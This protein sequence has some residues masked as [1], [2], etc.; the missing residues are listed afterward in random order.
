MTVVYGV[1]LQMP[2]KTYRSSF[3]R[4]VT[5]WLT[6]VLLTLIVLFFAFE[7]YPRFDA[8]GVIRLTCF[9]IMLAGILLP[10]TGLF[11]NHLSFVQ[12]TSLKFFDENLELSRN[13][14]KITIRLAEIYEVVEFSTN[15]KY[16]SGKLPWSQLV[17]WK[18]KTLEHEF[19]ISSLIISD[20]DLKKR[21]GIDLT[22]QLSY[23]PVIKKT[24]GFSENDEF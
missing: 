7:S 12:N 11:F 16:S 9:A 8:S 4:I 18:V 19:F 5:L 24:K 1:V 6:P 17:K 21:I 15:T 22:Y 23:F 13:D 2:E 10:F 14:K 3:A 20:T